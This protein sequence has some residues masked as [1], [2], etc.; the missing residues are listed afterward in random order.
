MPAVRHPQH[1]GDIIIAGAGCAGLSALWHLLQ[2]PLADRRI[3]IVD[4]TIEPRDDRTWSFWGPP[5]APFAWLADRSWRDVEVRFPSWTST[6][7]LGTWRGPRRYH[8]VRSRDYTAAILALAERQPNVRL[9]P[10]AMLGIDDEHDGAR[11]R[12]ALGDLRAPVVM[13]SVGRPPGGPPA[14]HPLRQHFGGWEVRTEHPIFRP[15][16]ATLMDF[17]APQDDGTAFFYL[18]PD[19]ADRALVEF[20]TFS[21]RPRDRTFYDHHVREYVADHGAGDVAVERT[22]YGCIPMEDRS[23]PQRCGHHVWNLGTVGGM[24]KPTSG[25]TFQRIHRH[26]RHLVDTM[27]AT[28]DPAELPDPPRRFAFGDRT[29]LHLLDHRPELGRTIFERLFRTTPIDRVLTFLDEASS[30][31][32]DARMVAHL[33][34]GPFLAAAAAETRAAWRDLRELDRAFGDAATSI[35]LDPAPDVH[36]RA[37]LFEAPVGGTVAA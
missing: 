21:R 36:V 30:L 12:T 25:Y 14:R 9:V 10:A 6:Q 2:S 24:T 27:A 11:V 7:R 8:R 1:D 32:Q 31:A 37:E 28:G 17:D 19:A 33:P 35:Q 29:L 20:T 5:D 13:Q 22:E 18:L 16:V 34:L 4:R 26:S 3:L 23:W 15:G